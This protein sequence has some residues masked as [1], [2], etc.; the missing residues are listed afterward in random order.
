MIVNCKFYGQFY[1]KLSPC[2]GESLEGLLRDC[3]QNCTSK[4]RCILPR[5]TWME[6]RG[7]R[8]IDEG[9]TMRIAD[10]SED[11]TSKIWEVGLQSGSRKKDTV[12]ITEW[13]VLLRSFILKAKQ[14]PVNHSV[15][16][17]LE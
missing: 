12:G 7:D 1:L 6:V 8:E 10:A 9:S 16:H 14:I 13:G 4:N 3:V 2:G 17:S 5:R 15:P 11:G